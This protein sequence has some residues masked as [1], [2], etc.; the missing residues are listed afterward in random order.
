MTN[1]MIPFKCPICGSDGFSQ[2]V[3]KGRLTEAYEC[4][5]CSVMFRERERFTQHRLTVMGA[6]GRDLKQPEGAR[7]KI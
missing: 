2:V 1:L 7:K 5:G 6:D 4:K 3:V